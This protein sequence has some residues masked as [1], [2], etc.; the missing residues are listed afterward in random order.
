VPGVG[1]VGEVDKQLELLLPNIFVIHTSLPYAQQGRGG[2]VAKAW[3]A[4]RAAVA[5]RGNPRSRL[6]FPE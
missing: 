3:Q 2:G 4:P 6:G 5:K 1:R